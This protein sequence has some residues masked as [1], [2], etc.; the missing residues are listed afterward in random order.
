MCSFNSCPPTDLQLHTILE[1]KYT[2]RN[3]IPNWTPGGKKRKK[4]YCH[5][6]F[7]MSLHLRFNIGTEPRIVTFL[8]L[9]CSVRIS[10]TNQITIT[11]CTHANSI[12]D[13]NSS[14]PS[15]TISSQVF[16]LA[17]TAGFAPAFALHL[18]FVS[19]SLP[20]LPFSFAFPLALAPQEP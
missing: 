1:T 8:R 4:N 16:G 11:S 17:L 13:P 19:C 15:S 18:S 5:M 3:P 12:T 7:H 2:V 6:I 14:S 10:Q 9:K 20:M